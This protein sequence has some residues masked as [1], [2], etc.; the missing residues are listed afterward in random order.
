MSKMYGLLL[1][2][3][4]PSE[5]ERLLKLKEQGYV[6]NT[7]NE[8]LCPFNNDGICVSPETG[9]ECMFEK[10]FDEGLQKIYD[11]R[12]PVEEREEIR[13]KLIEKFGR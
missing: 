4:Y 9:D 11:T 13:N 1:L 8:W 2:K 6:I 10:E 3:L 7:C 5:R 12:I